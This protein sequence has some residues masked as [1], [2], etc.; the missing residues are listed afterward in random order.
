[1]PSRTRT[2]RNSSVYFASRSSIKYRVP[3]RKPS[4][5]SVTL[6]NLCHPSIVGVGCDAGNVDRAG[7]NV[8]KEED[9]ISDQPF[10]RVHLDAQEIGRRH[11]L[12]VSFEKRRPSS[13]TVSFRGGLDAVFSAKGRWK[14]LSDEERFPL[15]PIYVPSRRQSKLLAS[16]VSALRSVRER[17][18]CREPF[19]R[20]HEL[21]GPRA[22]RP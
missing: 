2:S 3:L 19:Q 4:S 21:T 14:R 22:M 10:D 11:A 17:Q 8:D 1:M 5:A 7:G 6:R 18:Y 9:V 12:P 16:R 13:M 15:L 20:L